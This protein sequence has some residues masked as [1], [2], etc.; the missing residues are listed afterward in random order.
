MSLIPVPL[1]V[2]CRLPVPRVDGLPRTGT[3]LL[4]LTDACRLLFPADLEGTCDWAVLSAAWNP[5][6]LGFQL[7]VTGRKM[8]VLGRPK[9]PM[10]P[11]S[12]ELWI[13][14]RE[15][16][17]VHRATRYCHHFCVLP[18]G[19]GET[20]RE[21][22]VI[23]LPVARAREDSPIRDDEEFLCRSRTITGGY[24]LSVWFPAETLNGF[25]P[26]EQSRLG[27][28][29]RINDAEHGRRC[30]G[31]DDAF[32]FDA[33]PSLWHSLELREAGVTRKPR[34][35]EVDGV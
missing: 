10:E 34:A 14:T 30:F 20:G 24:E 16:Q 22:L 27:F 15:T 1:L 2:R 6:G 32:P 8:P 13:D 25:N 21:A 4:K 17:T 29:A 9:A 26:A 19:G 31:V 35:S 12:L 28:C 5:R 3:E 7:V 23:Q 33:D 11:D 18:N